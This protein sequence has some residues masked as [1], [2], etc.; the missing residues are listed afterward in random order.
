MTKYQYMKVLIS[1]LF[2]RKLL[3]PKTKK[4]YKIKN[5]LTVFEPKTKMFVLKPTRYH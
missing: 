2:N 3:L 1:K 5:D 4:S